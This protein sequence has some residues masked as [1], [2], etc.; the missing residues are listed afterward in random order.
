LP[1]RESAQKD[2]SQDWGGSQAVPQTTTVY[3]GTSPEAADSIVNSQSWLPGSTAWFTT[4]PDRASFYGGSVVSLDMP[5]H[6]V[7]KRQPEFAVPARTR[8]L[9]K[10]PFKMHARFERTAADDDD[11]RGQHQGPSAEYGAPMHDITG[12]G[13]YPD[14]VYSSP[15]DWYA[16]PHETGASESWSKML[17]AKDKPDHKVTVYRALPLKHTTPVRYPT[18]EDGPGFTLR[19]APINTG[20]WV[21]TSHDYAVD[22]GHNAL[23]NEPWAIVQTK[24]PA[25]HLHTDGNSINEWA[26]NGPATHGQETGKSENL[27]KR[28][29]KGLP[30]QKPVPLDQ[31][32]Q[33]GA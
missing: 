12:N 6:M 27:R 26:Y 18:D 4:D 19:H 31:W 32:Q 20:D 23:H 10:G 22:H 17:R 33:G 16:S 14:D 9:R 11:Y 28:L 8:I 3:H 25:Q 24:V 13:V 21:T 30:R 7:P 2:Y 1:W 5:S 29:F 15:M